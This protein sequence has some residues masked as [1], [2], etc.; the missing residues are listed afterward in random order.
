MGAAT[1]L[2]PLLFAG[3]IFKFAGLGA[4]AH[5]AQGFKGAGFRGSGAQSSGV[6]EFRGSGFRGA[7]LQGFRASGLQGLRGSW[8]QRLRSLGA[9]RFMG[10]MSSIVQGF[11]AQ[12]CRV[13]SR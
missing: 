7:G 9:H 8:A 11:R 10:L 13:S 3:R 1:R 12:G 2:A 6:Q 5:G 4:S